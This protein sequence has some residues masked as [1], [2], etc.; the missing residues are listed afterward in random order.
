MSEV[1][2]APLE[3][4]LLHTAPQQRPH[5]P[6]P[7]AFHTSFHSSTAKTQRQNKVQS[8]SILQTFHARSP[9]S[10]KLLAPFGRGWLAQSQLERSRA[11]FPSGY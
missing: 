9:T 6:R 7:P 10:A 8:A 5:L 3:A 4:H 2:R 11:S 1:S